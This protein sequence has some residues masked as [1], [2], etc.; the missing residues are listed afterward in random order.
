MPSTWSSITVGDGSG[1]KTKQMRYK[2][3]RPANLTNSRANMAP[4]VI[5]LDE[6]LSPAAII[7]WEQLAV[8]HRFVL[9]VYEPGTYHFPQGSGTGY[10]EPV[11][12]PWQPSPVP[13][14]GSSGTGR[15]D[16]KP[17]L[18]SLL[19]SVVARQHIDRKR[20]FVTGAS[21]GGAFAI[22][23]MCSASTNKLFRGFGVVSANIWSTG[24][25]EK[26]STNTCQSLNRDSS[27]MFFAGQA[28]DYIPYGGSTM[29]VRYAW[30][31]RDGVS[32]LAHR[33]G[34]ASGP[35][36]TFFGSGRALTRQLYA[37]CA[38]PHR[39]V[40]LISVPHGGHAY[41]LDGR[42]LDSEAEL[43]R[44]WASH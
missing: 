19:R 16:D 39:G 44:F 6:Q 32:S 2:V 20:I 4:A 8:T 15:C 3:Y 1:T 14:C 33:Y 36:T 7:R 31:Q 21:K 11:T 34:C 25:S 27:V 5:W 10:F 9:V 26:A 41:G 38:M 24:P 43:W 29:G 35:T 28:D 30:S 18:V 40:A 42:G 13:G 23:L 22:E 17:G 12:I 37:R